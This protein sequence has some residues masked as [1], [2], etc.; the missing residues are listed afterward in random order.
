MTSP[1]NLPACAICSKP[2]PLEHSKTDELGQAVHEDSYTAK[3]L[4]QDSDN[5]LQ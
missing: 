1:E 2:V 4:A 3:L 5:K